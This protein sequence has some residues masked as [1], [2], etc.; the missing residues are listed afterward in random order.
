MLR[1]Q[2]QNNIYVTRMEN[3]NTRIKFKCSRVN[4][5]VVVFLIYDFQ[6]SPSLHQNK[7]RASVQT[8]FI[9]GYNSQNGNKINFTV[10][11]NS[12]INAIIV[13]I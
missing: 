4:D 13:M 9:G 1:S 3:M 5:G 8:L 12:Y 6:F 11:N 7:T 10:I 2:R